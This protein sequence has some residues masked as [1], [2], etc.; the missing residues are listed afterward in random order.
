MRINLPNLEKK[1]DT[2]TFGPC[3]GINP[4]FFT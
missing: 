1:T 3:L 2:C 4:M